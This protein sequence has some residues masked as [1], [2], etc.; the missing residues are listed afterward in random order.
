VFPGPN[1]VSLQ[2]FVVQN[3]SKMQTSEVPA[4]EESSSTGKKCGLLNTV[5]FIDSTWYQVYKIATDPRLTSKIRLCSNCPKSAWG[6]V[7]TADRVRSYCV[8]C[9]LLQN[10]WSGV[11]GSVVRALEVTPVSLIT[12]IQR[13]KI[14]R[15]NHVPAA[16]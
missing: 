7:R 3:A 5:V 13:S 8:D 12:E 1:A 2:Q 15:G 10:P 4:V 11:L 14:V 6:R 9:R 16:Q